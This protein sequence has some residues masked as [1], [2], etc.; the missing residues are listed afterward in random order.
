MFCLKILLYGGGTDQWDDAAYIS[1]EFGRLYLMKFC[2]DI[3]DMYG[4]TYLKRYPNVDEM[5]EITEKFAL[6]GFPG[7]ARGIGLHEVVLEELSCTVRGTESESEG[8][9]PVG[10]DTM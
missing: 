1:E 2:K 4:S 7:C 6:Q 5:D 8:A 9:F 10:N 3:I